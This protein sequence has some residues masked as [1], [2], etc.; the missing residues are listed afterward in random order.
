M[1]TPE[2]DAPPPKLVVFDI[3]NVLL[4]FEPLHLYRDLLPAPA[5]AHPIWDQVDLHGMN[6][7]GDLGRLQDAVAA[8]AA[9]HPAYQDLILPWFDQWERMIGPEIPGVADILHGV[10]A[11]GLPIAAFS[12]FSVDT[13]PRGKARFP[14]L[15]AFDYEF[16]SGRVNL[17]KPDPAFYALLEA[18]T[19]CSGGDVFFVDDKAENIEAAARRGWRT[20]HFTGTAATLGAALSANGVRLD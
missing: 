1:T 9:A 2:P 14:I 16:I 5:E 3:G 15:G 7:A 6:A 10:K 12:N 17:A 11:A 8:T 4:R 18:E 13:F 19:G 20:C